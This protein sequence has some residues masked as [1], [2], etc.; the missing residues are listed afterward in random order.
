MI[1]AEASVGLAASLAIQDFPISLHTKLVQEDII[2]HDYDVM[3]EGRKVTI[4]KKDGSVCFDCSGA[5]AYIDPEPVLRSVPQDVRQPDICIRSPRNP[6]LSR[7]HSRLAKLRAC[8]D[9]ILISANALGH[10]IFSA[11]TSTLQSLSIEYDDN[12]V[13]E[14]SDS[15]D[16]YR[17]FGV[18]VSIASLLRTL[19]VAGCGTEQMQVAIAHRALILFIFNTS[20]ARITAILPNMDGI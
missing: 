18:T 3:V 15:S 19:R 7:L 8:A 13:V 1:W 2:D 17:L 14:C 5:Q 11:S 9:T 16:E 10:L 4:R 20:C 12:S 6:N